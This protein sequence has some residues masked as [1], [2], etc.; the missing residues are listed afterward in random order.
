MPAAYM[1]YFESGLLATQAN[2]KFLIEKEC[3][4]L[5]SFGSFLSR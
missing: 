3:F 4:G 2:W 5:Q 1:I